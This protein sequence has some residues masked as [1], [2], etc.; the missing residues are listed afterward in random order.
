MNLQARAGGRWRWLVLDSASP[1][2]QRALHYGAPDL[3]ALG[4]GTVVKQSRTGW[5]QRR[6]DG[7]ATSFAKTYVYPTARDRRRGLCR[8]TCCARSRA[9][10][11][12]DAAAWLR[13]RGFAAPR[14]LVLAELRRLGVLHAALIVTEAIAGEPLDQV[15][16][17]LGA[18][19]RD[20]VLRALR[21]FVHE[22]HRSGF[23]DRNLDLRN[24]LLL[25]GNTAPAFAKVDS[26]RFRIVAPGVGDDRL[27]QEDWRRLTASLASL[28][29]AWPA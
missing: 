5:V 29:L 16:P 10:R 28:G 4:R 9:R 8:N 22:L 25:A 23:R 6:Q 14:V 20:E 26:P 15:L 12:A 18:S 21:N 27:A 19:R 2:G 24:V 7:D 3:A 13:A 17:R 1:A 11:E